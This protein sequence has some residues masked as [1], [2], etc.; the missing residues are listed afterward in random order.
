MVVPSFKILE[1]FDQ[2]ELIAYEDV[3]EKALAEGAPVET[4]LDELEERSAKKPMT[5]SKSIPPIERA[6]FFNDLEKATRR[7][8]S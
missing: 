8:G 1:I 3:V 2:P 4:A 5:R 6:Q 7:K